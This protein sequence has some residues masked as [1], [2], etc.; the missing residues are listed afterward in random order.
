MSTVSCFTTVYLDPLNQALADEFAT[1]SST[2]T[3]SVEQYRAL[4]EKLQTHKPDTNATRTSFT[5]PFED[6]VK[7]FIFRPKGV[8][9]TLPV[10]CFLHGGGWIAGRYA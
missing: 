2:A 6:G 8:E 3:L 10:I 5:V 7:T 1:Q 4:F 9:G